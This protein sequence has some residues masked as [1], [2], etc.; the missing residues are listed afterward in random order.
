MLTLN[1]P[2]VPQIMT[3][4]DQPDALDAPEFPALLNLD[5]DV[6]PSEQVRTRPLR[7][8]CHL[9][10]RALAACTEPEHAR[11]A[12]DHAPPDLAPIDDPLMLLRS[13]R[14]R[15]SSLGARSGGA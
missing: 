10:A 2:A 5:D 14:L 9:L 7:A 8:R 15:G 1:L 12:A 6:D 13:R 4:D 11:R 3:N